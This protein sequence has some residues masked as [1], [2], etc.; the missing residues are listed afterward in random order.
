[1]SRGK[2]T[3]RAKLKS[4]SQEERLYN[5]KEHFVNLLVNPPEITDKPIKE[6]ING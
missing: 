6:I 5:L 4:A 2:I 3:S 1:M